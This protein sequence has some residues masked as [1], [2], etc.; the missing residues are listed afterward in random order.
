MAV[1]PHP[2]KGKGHWYIDYR[3]EGVKG[4]RK[5]VPFVGTWDQ[6]KK[7]EMELRR[8]IKKENVASL[9]PKISEVIPDWINYYKIDHLDGGIERTQRSLKILLRFF[10]KYQF[11]SLTPT[12]I[13]SY[14]RERLKEV[15]PTTINKELA[16]LSGLCKW[17]AEQGYCQPIKIRRFS[18]KLTRAPLPH[19][20]TQ[21]NIERLLEAIPWPKCGLYGCM[22]YGGLR[23]TEAASLKAENVSLE[24]KTM[25]VTGKGNKERVVPILKM[26]EPVLKCRLEEIKEGYLWAGPKGNPL[27]DLRPAIKWALIR[28][29]IEEKITPHSL[30]HA[31]GVRAVMAGVP[32]RLIQIVLGHSSVKVTEIYTQIAADQLGGEFE[33]F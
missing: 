19:V 9:F 3:P 12:L 25:T 22:Y 18:S 15:K 11:T 27:V 2:T 8:Q 23:K 13:E 29:G 5:M 32:L 26:L 24:R 7:L 21:K 28:S 30:R 33:N 4:K 17:A 6:A 16:T 1:R 20:P 10:G 14:K 31:F